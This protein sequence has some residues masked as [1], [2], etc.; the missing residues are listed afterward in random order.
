MHGLILKQEQL[1]DRFEYDAFL[2]ALHRTADY[3][4]AYELDTKYDILQL[5]DTAFKMTLHEQLERHIHEHFDSYS[6]PSHP[7]HENGYVP[8]ISGMIV[9]VAK[10]HGIELID[11]MYDILRLAVRYNISLPTKSFCGSRGGGFSCIT[12]SS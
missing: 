10:Q 8:T 11:E 9:R 12:S 5:L 6:E 4:Y 1:R 7:I 2:Q 3:H